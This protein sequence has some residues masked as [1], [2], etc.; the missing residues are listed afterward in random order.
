MLTRFQYTGIQD[1]NGT[2]AGRLESAGNYHPSV[3]A[4]LILDAIPREMAV[5]NALMIAHRN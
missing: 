3:Y 5:G 4:Q 2:Q 1:L